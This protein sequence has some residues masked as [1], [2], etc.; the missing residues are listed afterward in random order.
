M[1][2]VLLRTGLLS[3]AGIFQA[4]TPTLFTVSICGFYFA[5]CA[6]FPF[7]FSVIAASDPTG[8]ASAITPAVDGL[9][10]AA[11]ATLAGGLLPTVGLQ[12]TGWIYAASSI[13]GIGC[14]VASKA[15]LNNKFG[16][17]NGS[18]PCNTLEET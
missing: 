13:I 3:L 2:L 10:L 12:A 8:R 15:M 9:G 16:A 1:L 14:Y 18:E 7:Q 4:S 5:W 6:S 11:G 17:R